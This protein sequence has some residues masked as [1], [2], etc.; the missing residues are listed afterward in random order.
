MALDFTIRDIM[1]HIT[2]KFSQA[3]LPGAKKRFHL[4]AV[5]QPEL[6]IH[7]I[8][9]KAAIYNIQTSARVIEEGLIAAME[10]LFYLIADGFKIKLPICN[11][12]I[13]LPGEYDGTETHLEEGSYP[14][15]SI[16]VTAGLR[17]YIKDR[18]ILDFDGIDTADGL[19]GVLIDDET[20]IT[21]QVI[22]RDNLFTVLGYGLKVE[23]DTA[24]SADVGVFF[25]ASDGTRIKAK[26]VA[27]NEPRELKVIAPPA[28]TNGEGYHVVIVTQ[29]SAKHGSTILKNPR[30]VKSEYTLT[31][32]D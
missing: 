8:A 27:I 5:F 22:T 12:R 6:D 3:F 23:G 13:R 10:L 28:L 11:I 17:N 21:D 15:A 14:E 30:E 24:H 1:H 4:K 26:A 20:G 9:S 31:A 2:V 16:T 19:I 29:S 32:Q 7:G 25:E 18:V